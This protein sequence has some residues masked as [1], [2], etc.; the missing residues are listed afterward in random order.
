[1][2]AIFLKPSDAILNFM[3]HPGNPGKPRPLPPTE[4]STAFCAHSMCLCMC[5][6]AF[7]QSTKTE[8]VHQQG[9]CADDIFQ[10]D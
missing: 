6:D 2:H 8:M 3:E 10:F 5:V 7:L 9:T 1:M 4:K